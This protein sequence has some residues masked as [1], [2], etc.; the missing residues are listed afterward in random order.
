VI[1]AATAAIIPKP[2]KRKRKFE[3]IADAGIS[4]DLALDTLSAFEWL[5]GQEMPR[6]FKKYFGRDDTI[7]RD[8]HT[9]LIR[10][11]P[12]IRFAT[13]AFVHLGVPETG[14][15]YT[16]ETIAAAVLTVRQGKTRRRGRRGRT[17]PE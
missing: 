8:R 2:L 9:G 13:E 1:K 11:S 14:T 7:S 17:T 15:P 5:A 3:K 12:F 16:I 6:L 4:K 10:R